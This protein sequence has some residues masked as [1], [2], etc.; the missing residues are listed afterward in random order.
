MKLLLALFVA[1][2]ALNATTYTVCA[3]ITCD[4]HT[5]PDAVTAYGSGTIAP[6]SIIEMKC[7]EDFTNSSV[8]WPWVSNPRGLMTVIR[9][10][11]YQ[12]L[13]ARGVRVDK[14]LHRKLMP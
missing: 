13:P 4:Y 7:N 8:E 6:G 5:L 2:G 1:A 10:S 14:T 12:Q 9:T 3:A 11:C